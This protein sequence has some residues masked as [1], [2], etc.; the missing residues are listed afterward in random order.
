MSRAA[1]STPWRPSFPRRTGWSRCC[2]SA[3][4]FAP[5][6]LRRGS[7]ICIAGWRFQLMLMLAVWG[8]PLGSQRS[9]PLRDSPGPRGNTMLSWFAEP[10]RTSS[11]PSFL[12]DSRALSVGP[13]PATRGGV[14]I[15]DGASSRSPPR[16]ARALPASAVMPPRL[17]AFLP[18]VVSG[19]QDQPPPLP[20]P[21]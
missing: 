4:V 18:S 8:P 1:G 9:R 20:R 10:C 13:S 19:P 21:P 11:P 6:G 3:R 12:S 5:A 17:P 2:G 14:D 16:T 15:P 7:R